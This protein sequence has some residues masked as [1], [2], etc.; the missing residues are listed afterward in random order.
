[1]NSDK[2]LHR[3]LSKIV[4][5]ET[6]CWLWTGA[7]DPAGYGRISYEGRNDKA[8]RISHLLFKGSIPEGMDTT[9]SCDNKGCVNPDHLF[10]QTRS[11]HK[12]EHFAKGDLNHKGENSPTH[13]LTEHDVLAIRMNRVDSNVDLAK[14][15]EVSPNHISDIRSGK[16][17]RHSILEGL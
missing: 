10:V 4:K 5:C 2:L 11:E 9:H 17:W 13:K 15:F 1:M 6:G 12:K 7:K 16:R 3:F 14:R 8:H